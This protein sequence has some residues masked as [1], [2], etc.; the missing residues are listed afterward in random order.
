MTNLA[1]ESRSQRR[2]PMTP[3]AWRALAD[4]LALLRVDLTTLASAADEGDGLVDFRVAQTARRLDLLTGVLESAEAIDDPECAVIGRRTTRVD[5]E[6]EGEDDRV[7]YV[8][9]YPG[10]GDPARGWVSADSPLGAAI[11]G[12]RAGESVEVHAPA[13]RRRVTVV[14]VE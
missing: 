7:S 10:E 12:A 6:G 5:G 14:A 13:G 8:L 3:E 4:E 2:W 1:L 9:V 11:L